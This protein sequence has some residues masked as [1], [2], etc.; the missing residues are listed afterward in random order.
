MFYDESSRFNLSPNEYIYNLSVCVLISRKRTGEFVRK[1]MKCTLFMV[2]KFILI[3]FSSQLSSANVSFFR[4]GQKKKKGTRA[5]TFE[6]K[7]GRDRAALFGSCQILYD[8][9]IL[10]VINSGM[11]RSPTTTTIKFNQ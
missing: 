8:I 1:I 6:M 3:F 10:R 9:I 11:L 7:N 4:K 2:Y 5:H